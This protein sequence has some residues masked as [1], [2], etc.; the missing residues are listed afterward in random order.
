MTD[1]R[2]PMRIAYLT[3]QYPAVSHTFIRRE[4]R[5]L[6]R[7][8]HTVVRCAIRPSPGLLVDPE[9]IEEAARTFHCVSVPKPRVIGA[10]GAESLSRPIRTLAAALMAI[11]CGRRSPAGVL[12][13]LL[14]LAEAI[15]L[16]RRLE[17]ERIEHV[18][19][20]FGTNPAMVARLIR[21]LGGPGFSMTIHGPD[22]L[23]DPRGHDLRGKIADARFTV[24][25]SDFTRSQLMRW[26][27]R[28]DWDRLHVVRCT[29]G[30][31]D[32]NPDQIAPATGTPT[33]VNVGRLSAQKGQLT[34]IDGFAELVERGVDA[35]L[36]I[37][38]DGELRTAVEGAVRDKGLSD[39]VTLT[40]SLPGSEVRQRL[41]ESHALVLPSFA[42]GL[43]MV[44]MEA[45]AVGVPVISTTIAGIPELVEHDR[46]GILVAPGRPDLIAD[47]M[48][49]LLQ[50]PADE[51]R[52]MAR[53]GRDAV[54]RRHRTRTEGSVLESLIREA[55][56]R[57]D[58]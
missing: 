1:R 18:H 24:A 16:R 21:S 55:I 48:E 36:T 58:R 19:V 10:I 17:R 34:L 31:E 14:Y 53:R 7:R 26:A 32:L 9:D 5:E 4:L 54:A 43:P 47:A 3:N 27:D 39:R 46:S 45:F 2:P 22:E 41:A 56:D 42:E 8:G 49:R 30:D 11:R 38:G 40:G 20:H 33:F 52:E 29:V 15:V 57:S 13:H 6:E 51:R 12:K 44:I 50:T 37:V 23:D 28:S 35:R 25:I